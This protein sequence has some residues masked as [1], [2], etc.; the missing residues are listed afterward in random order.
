MTW[1]RT[2]CTRPGEFAQSAYG[3]V[4]AECELIRMLGLERARIADAAE[5]NAGRTYSVTLFDEAL[6]Q[7]LW[8]ARS[9]S[10]YD[11]IASA[12]YSG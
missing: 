2:Q 4:A 3:S 12:N 1:N 10:P 9:L 6:N 5:K 11:M 8:L 7:R